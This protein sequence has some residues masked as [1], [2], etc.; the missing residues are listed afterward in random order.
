MTYEEYKRR[1]DQAKPDD[2]VSYNGKKMTFAQA[3]RAMKIDGIGIRFR[4]FITIYLPTILKVG[5]V[6]GI[7]T[8]LFNWSITVWGKATLGVF[9]VN[10][11]RCFVGG[12]KEKLWKEKLCSVIISISDAV[13]A[14]AVIVN[15]TK[16]VGLIA[17]IFIG[18]IVYIF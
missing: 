15:L 13:I 8:W 2:I 5:A 6:F 7:F 12:S 18:I 9:L 14:I 10:V 16:E 3:K 11:V 17:A 4:Y 1:W